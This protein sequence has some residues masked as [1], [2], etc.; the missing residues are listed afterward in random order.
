LLQNVWFSTPLVGKATLVNCVV[1]QLFSASKQVGGFEVALENS[2]HLGVVNAH[3]VDDDSVPRTSESFTA[4]DA[5]LNDVVVAA[6]KSDYQSLEN[7]RR[8]SPRPV[9]Q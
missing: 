6:L 2:P 5:P 8:S 7:L 3:T 9:E 4:T 1:W